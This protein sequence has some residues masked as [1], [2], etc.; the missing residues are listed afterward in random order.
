MGQQN[1]THHV[2]LIR[3]SLNPSHYFD[4]VLRNKFS[5]TLTLLFLATY[6]DRW[7]TFFADVFALMRPAESTSQTSFNPH[8]SLLFF[9]FVIEISEEVADQII[10]GARQFNTDRHVR[11]AR[12][13]DAVRERDAARINEAVLTIV[14]DYVERLQVLMKSPTATGRETS[15]VLEVVDWG[16]RTFGSYAGVSCDWCLSA[17]Y[18]F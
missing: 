18:R 8:V 13:R 14:A 4:P 11:D 1:P 15:E 5:H 16:I 6:L 2:R 9:H 10:K 7:P 12:V 3:P 17:H